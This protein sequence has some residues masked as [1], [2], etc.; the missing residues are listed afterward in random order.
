MTSS[1]AINPKYEA[2]KYEKMLFLNRV[3]VGSVNLLKIQL[4]SEFYNSFL[5]ENDKVSFKL[6]L[7]ASEFVAMQNQ[8]FPNMGEL[9]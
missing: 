1:D 3:E 6:K 5:N 9:S 7:N 4:E 8:L 2:I